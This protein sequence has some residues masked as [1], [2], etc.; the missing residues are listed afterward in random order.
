MFLLVSRHRSIDARSWS[1]DAG[2]LQY[3]AR[4]TYGKMSQYRANRCAC[5]L[6]L[7]TMTRSSNQSSA[8]VDP[9]ARERD[10][11]NRSR[12]YS[13]S[14]ERGVGITHHLQH[15][16]EEYRI[17]RSFSLIDS[18]T[19]DRFFSHLLQERKMYAASFLI[20]VLRLDS[21]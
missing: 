16:K 14:K 15:Y 13:Y 11:H 10:E 7:S 18:G 9:L 6:S 1:C 3:L 17:S 21:T 12:C 2:A 20:P 8:R 19:R 5:G 4:V